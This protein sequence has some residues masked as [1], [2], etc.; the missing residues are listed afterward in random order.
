M[1]RPSRG[2][3]VDRL[4]CLGFRLSEEL[5]CAGERTLEAR[6]SEARRA[7]VVIHDDITWIDVEKW[8]VCHMEVDFKPVED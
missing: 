4:D 1:N 5:V 2:T 8:V 7:E 3:R 6:S